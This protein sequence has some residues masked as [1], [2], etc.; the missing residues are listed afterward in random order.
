VA[1]MAIEK[2]ILPER[3]FVGASTFN[4]AKC[5]FYIKLSVAGCGG[6]AYAQVRLYFSVSWR[7]EQRP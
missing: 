2:P 6:N 3:D 7:L 1:G 4:S 5:A